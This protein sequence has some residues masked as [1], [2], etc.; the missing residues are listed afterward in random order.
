VST[1]ETIAAF[2]VERGYRLEPSPLGAAVFATKK[3]RGFGIF[4]PYIDY[5]A[6]HD[7]D[8]LDGDVASFER[9]HEQARSHAASQFRLPR[10]MRYRIPNIVSIGVSLRGLAPEA[11]GAAW[12]SDQPQPSVGGERH[13]AY[14]LDVAHR[15]IHILGG[16][17][18]SCRGDDAAGA[19][20]NPRERAH[21]LVASLASTVFAAADR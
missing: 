20:I 13:S 18:L 11:I 2:L 3:G 16:A 6:V 21:S 12:R 15:R 17:E 19:R 7:L 1:F 4:F 14:L 9:L 10:A 5:V 8:I